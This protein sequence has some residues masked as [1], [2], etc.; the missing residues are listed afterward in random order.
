MD[1]NTSGVAFSRK[2]DVVLERLTFRIA[3]R[4]RPSRSQH[5]AYL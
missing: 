2:R 3:K 4:C 5:S 1:G